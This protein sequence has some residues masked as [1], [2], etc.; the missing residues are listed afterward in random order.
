MPLAAW[1]ETNTLNGD[2][3]FLAVR[4]AARAM[5]PGDGGSIVVVSSVLAT[6]PSPTLFATHGYAASKGAAL[7]LVRSTA[8]YYAASNVRVNALTP[9]LIET[10]MSARAATDEATMGYIA[11]KQPLAAGM[12][13]AKAVAEA[14]LFLLSTEARFITGQ[15]IAIDGGWSVTEA[16][17]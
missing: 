17:P 1:R 14:G 16:G 15:V 5:V 8:A 2:P 9:A 12:L 3:L 4:E 10:P 13:P 6:D 11:K 7:S